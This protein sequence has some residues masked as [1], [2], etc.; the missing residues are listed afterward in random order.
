MQGLPGPGIHNPKKIE[1]SGSR[2]CW[3][4]ALGYGMRESSV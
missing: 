3:L 4:R 2:V 1:H